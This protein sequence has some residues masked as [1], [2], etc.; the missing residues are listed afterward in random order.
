[1]RFQTGRVAVK[2][3][4]GGYLWQ[5]RLPCGAPW[6]RPDFGG[7]APWC[8]Y[9]GQQRGQAAGVTG[10][11]AATGPVFGEIYPLAV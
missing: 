3:G 4:A 11:T 9:S 8:P 5:S 2:R 7:L 10:V 1:M 6:R